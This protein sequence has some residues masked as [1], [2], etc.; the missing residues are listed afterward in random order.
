MDNLNI[1]K[2]LTEAL[3]V[4]SVSVIRN[5]RNSLLSSSLFTDKDVFLE[6]RSGKILENNKRGK[7]EKEKKKIQELINFNLIKKYKFKK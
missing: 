2:L 7:K 3:E 1:E 4:S 5:V 6:S